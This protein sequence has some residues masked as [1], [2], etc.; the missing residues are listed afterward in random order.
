M[1][2]QKLK[3][4]LS[5]SQAP[6]FPAQ[7]SYC[8]SAAKV[9]AIWDTGC[10]TTSLDINIIKQLGLKQNKNIPSKKTS[11]A[12]GDM[13]SR[14]FNVDILFPGEPSNFLFKNFLISDHGILDVTE[15]DKNKPKYLL[16]GMDII[17]KG[18]FVLQPQDN[19]NIAI[20]IMLMQE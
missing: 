18:I 16:V 11:T 13:V 6:K 15:D 4:Q 12:N 17:E 5:K 8:G 14:Y 20:W 7:V 9:I 3:L 10:D 2:I 19:H 1:K